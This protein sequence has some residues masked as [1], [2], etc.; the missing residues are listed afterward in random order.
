MIAYITALL[1]IIGALFC[2]VSAI[3]L[4]R[5]P[6]LYTRMHAASKAGT[7]GSGIM[8]CAI[9]VASGEAD[10]VLRTLAGIVF[11]LLT[12]PISAH[13]LARAAYC[14]GLQPHGSIAQDDLKDRYHPDTRRLDSASTD[15]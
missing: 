3:G 1:L 14:A 8:L 15:V 2:L 4:L 10:V 12:A 7:V 6:D 9:A 5:L 13:L 11:F